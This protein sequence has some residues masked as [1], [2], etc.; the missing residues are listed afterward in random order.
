[1]CLFFFAALARLPATLDGP[2][3]SS[4]EIIKTFAKKNYNK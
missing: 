2:I 4:K 1:M 3:S